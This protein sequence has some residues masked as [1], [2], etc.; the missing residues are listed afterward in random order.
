MAKKRGRPIGFK[1]S[2]E[3]KRAISKSKT[4]HKHSEETKD[5]ISRSLIAYFRRKRPMSEEI[6]NMYCRVGDDNM[7]DWIMNIKDKLDSYEEMKTYRAIL[8]AEQYEGACGSNIELL[9]HSMTPELLLL[10]K[11]YCREYNL[12]FDNVFDEITNS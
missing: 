6:I 11:E 12:D 3:T 4:G 9:S 5:K 1:L 2:D 8:T 10:F 7:C